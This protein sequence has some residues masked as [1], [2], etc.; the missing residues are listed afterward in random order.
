MWKRIIPMTPE[1]AAADLREHLRDNPY[2]VT[3][4]DS[5]TDKGVSLIVYVTSMEQASTGIKATYPFWHGYPVEVHETANAPRRLRNDAHSNCLPL[6]VDHLIF[7]IEGIVGKQ[8]DHE[9]GWL[10]NMLAETLGKWWACLPDK[11]SG[12]EHD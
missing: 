2:L 8:P 3:V 12:G 7:Q 9:R 4:V 11:P 10:R 6:L 1:E 5:I